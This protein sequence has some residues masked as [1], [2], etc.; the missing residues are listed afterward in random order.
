MQRLILRARRPAAAIRPCRRRTNFNACRLNPLDGGGLG[1]RILAH[2]G[3]L[4]KM[5]GTMAEHAITET[6]PDA[7]FAEHV[8]TYHQFLSILKY[9]LVGVIILLII[10]AVTTQLGRVG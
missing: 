1:L 4:N 9:G 8:R 5:G 6:A 7:D 3:T 2:S 10:L